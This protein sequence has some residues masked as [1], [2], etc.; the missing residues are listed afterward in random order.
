[1][2]QYGADTISAMKNFVSETPA[3]LTQKTSKLEKLGYLKRT[4]NKSDRR[5][6]NF[7]ITAKGKKMIEKVEKLSN[8][9]CDMFNKFSKKNREKFAEILDY[10]SAG[11]IKSTKNYNKK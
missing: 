1:M 5:I 2:I 10:V 11:L 9:H 7:K 3:S 4:L 6:W 8:Q